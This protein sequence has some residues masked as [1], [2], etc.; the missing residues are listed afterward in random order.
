[1]ITVLLMQAQPTPLE[2]TPAEHTDFI[3][4]VS[5]WPAFLVTV[6]AVTLAMVTLVWYWRRRRTRDEP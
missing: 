4:V 6:G 2:F 5:D 3:F 1:M